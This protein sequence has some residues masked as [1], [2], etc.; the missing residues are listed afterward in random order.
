MKILQ[1]MLVALA[2][3][4]GYVA[5][6]FSAP[7]DIPAKAEMKKGVRPAKHHRSMSEAMMKDLDLSEAQ[8][9]Q[10]KEISAQKKAEMAPLRDEMKKL[11][12]Q[13]QQINKKYEAKIRGILNAEQQ[14]K[15]ESML[16]KK[17]AKP[18]GKKPHKSKK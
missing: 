12:K 6:S 18:E 15:Y 11:H 9:K 7:A 13:E 17:P 5:P 3:T 2:L 1:V 16:P 10:W 4:I 14:A 8:K